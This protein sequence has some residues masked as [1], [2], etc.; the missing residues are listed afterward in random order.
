[1]GEVTSFQRSKNTA[2]Y[3]EDMKKQEVE[4]AVKLNEEEKIT[5]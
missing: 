3:V 5:L 1:M 4:R 2:R